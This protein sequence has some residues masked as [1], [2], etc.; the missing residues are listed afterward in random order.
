MNHRILRGSLL[1]TCIALSACGGGG[2]TGGGETPPPS[3]GAPPIVSFS[4]VFPQGDATAAQGVA[5][6]I[7]GVKTSL[8]GQSGDNAGQL[9]DTLRV[10]VS[11][12][13]DILNALPPAG[14]SLSSGSQL[15]VAIQFDIDHNAQTGSFDTCSAGSGLQPFEFVS[16]PGGDPGRLADGNYTIKSALGAIYSGSP[17]PPEEARV[18]VSGRVFTETFYLPAI[19][20]NSGPSIPEVGLAVGVLNGAAAGTTDCVPA[21]SGELFTNHQ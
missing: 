9:Y 14:T 11:F 3:Q 8:S 2:G 5:W 1:S 21:G 7:V 19:D 10:D 16:D 20:V 13:Q 15:G 17:N 4:H 18:S 12:S 6:D